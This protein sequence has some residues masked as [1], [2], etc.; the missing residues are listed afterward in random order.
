MTG[1]VTV[2]AVTTAGGMQTVD[3]TLVA[4]PADTSQSVLKSNRSSLKGTIPIVLNY[5]LFC[6]IYQAI[7]SKFLKG[8]NLCNQVLTC[9]I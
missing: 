7:R 8:W 6:T 5:V 1:S 4:G 2:S 3:I 9:P